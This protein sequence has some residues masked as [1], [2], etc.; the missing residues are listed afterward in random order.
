MAARANEMDLTAPQRGEPETF[1]NLYERMRARVYNLAARIVRDPDDAADITQDVFATTFVRRPWSTA[2]QP[3]DRWI[4]R[5]TVNA[6]YDHLRRTKRRATCPLP[7]DDSLTAHGDG[8]E[9]SYVRQA[10]EQALHELPP[11]YRVALVL[12]DLHGMDTEEIAAAM[13]TTRA[14]ARV[15]LFRARSSFRRTFRQAVPAAGPQLGALGLAAF[16][17]NLPLPAS[18]QAPLALSGVPLAPVG[19][20][21][22][23]SPMAT[24]A[25][26][27][28]Q[29]APASPLIA[30]PLAGLLAKAGG[31][32]GAKAV[33]AAAAAI[34]VAGGG[35]AIQQAAWDDVQPA[36]TRRHAAVA[37]AAV[38]SGVPADGRH[39]EAAVRRR[40]N[41]G[42]PSAGQGPGG[43][44][45]N[46]RQGAAAGPAHVGDGAG[47]SANRT[48]ALSGSGSG[49]PDD[50]ARGLG[51]GSPDAKGSGKGS[52]DAKGSRSGSPDAGGSGKGSGGSSTGGAR[53]RDPGRAR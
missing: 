8:L 36:V 24:P 38:T 41:P 28:V 19:S 45:A 22:T 18:L 14:T 26:P 48:G 34:A 43:G 32:V 15:V 21:A 27:G 10:V 25:L 30:S 3:V 39:R 6:C 31:T 51:K 20:A 40:G 13:G 1:E 7:D 17:P 42:R 46:G 49:G 5:V 4:Y 33:L 16:L 52:P 9:Q 50:A 35:G 53:G 37:S 11:R 29:P 23:P 44:A 47:G 2:E 12:K